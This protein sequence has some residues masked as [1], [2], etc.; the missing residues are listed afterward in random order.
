MK[1]PEPNPED[2][3]EDPGCLERV[4]S[5][6]FPCIYPTL[7]L[8]VPPTRYNKCALV[9]LA[10]TN[11][12]DKQ[13]VLSHESGEAGVVHRFR[14]A[15][16]VRF[17]LSFAWQ[18]GNQGGETLTLL[19]CHPLPFLP[20]DVIL[21]KAEYQVPEA[22][23]F[24]LDVADACVLS[25]SPSEAKQRDVSTKIARRVREIERRGGLSPLTCCCSPSPICSLRLCATLSTSSQSFE[26]R[27][28]TVARSHASLL[29]T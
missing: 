15:F 17:A 22:N 11:S 12:T 26:L 4:L 25:T 19:L 2:V 14:K 1:R 13:H 3:D 16:V 8:P 7:T 28:V 21:L 5:T 23:L 20:Q 24:S 18:A 6:L 27:V 10:G 9:A 29:I